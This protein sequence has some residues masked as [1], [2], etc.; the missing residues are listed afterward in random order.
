MCGSQFKWPYYEAKQGG[1]KPAY[2][3]TAGWEISFQ[4]TD[5]VPDNLL[6]E[7]RMMFYLP[8]W[9]TLLWMM[10]TPGHAM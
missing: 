8:P 5:S 4:G 1:R 2:I 9:P 6:I 7:A 10:K 3:L